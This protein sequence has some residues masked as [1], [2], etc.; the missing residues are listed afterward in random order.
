MDSDSRWALILAGGDGTRLRPLTRQLVGDDRPKQFCRLFGGDTLL[1]QTL[2]R[3]ARVIPTA[4]TVAVLVQS[5]ER[6]YAPLMADV[7]SR[8]LVIQP[9]NRGTLPAILYGLLRL[10][11]IRAEGSVA[12]FPSDHYISDDEVFAGFVERAF[13]AAE[14]RRDLVISLGVVPD[15]AEIG[16]G[17][18]ELGEGIDGPAGDLYRVRRF[19]E[20]PSAELADVLLTRSCLWNSFVIVGNIATLLALI[21]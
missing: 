5:H 20:K 19:W 17:W 15:S 2:R 9:D 7:P 14:A 10:S 3:A 18:I 1:E 12:M 11:A 4:R 16:Y 13:Q 8:R 6:F 21:R